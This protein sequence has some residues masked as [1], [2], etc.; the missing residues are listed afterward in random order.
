[1]TTLAHED[2][3]IPTVPLLIQGE[4]VESQSKE[5]TNVVNPATQQVLARVPQATVQEVHAAIDAAH[6]AFA[7]WRHTPI[8][9]R[10]RVMLRLQA[11]IRENS[12]RIAKILTAEQGKTLADAEGDIHHISDHC[13]FASLSGTDASDNCVA[14]MH[15]HPHLDTFQK[16]GLCSFIKFAQDFSGSLNRVLA[17]VSMGKGSAE[18][19]EETVAQKFV[20]EPVMF[21]YGANHEIPQRVQ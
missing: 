1:M 19:G 16:P 2:Q 20:N 3:T 9:A 11:L 18:N 12:K 17:V 8:G 7:T 21:I 6:H 10:V 5:F 14:S 4:W 13:V 15:G